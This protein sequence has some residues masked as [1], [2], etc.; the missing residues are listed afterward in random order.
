[1]KNIHVLCYVVIMY[2]FFCYVLNLFDQDER[3]MI[4]VRKVGLQ[5]VASFLV[6]DDIQALNF[7]FFGCSERCD[8]TYNF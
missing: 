3:Y 2:R 5:V 4:V 6:V 8:H 1:M 7:L